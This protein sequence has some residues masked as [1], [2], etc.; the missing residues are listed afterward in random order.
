LVGPASPEFGA[1]DTPLGAKSGKMSGEGEV[2][3]VGED[4]VGA[5]MLKVIDKDAKTDAKAPQE[6]NNKGKIDPHHGADTTYKKLFIGGLAWQT[7]TERLKEHFAHYG[8]LVEAVVITDKT[9]GRSKGYGF[10]TY[11]REEDA[12]KA[13]KNTS[14]TIDGRRTNCNLAAFGNV[15]RDRPGA[16]NNFEGRNNYG[17]RGGHN[18][19][20]YYYD[21]QQ[22]MMYGNM[23]QQMDNSQYGGMG[24]PGAMGGSPNQ[25]GNFN[26][27][28]YMAFPAMMMQP[29]AAGMMMTPQGFMMA[30]QQQFDGA[31]GGGMM[32]GG[33]MQHG[34]SPNQPDMGDLQALGGAM[35]ELTLAN[36]SDDLE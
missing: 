19:G 18:G 12:S 36:E 24:F 10:V 21:Q 32:Y 15:R 22:M 25:M 2:V 16:R 6:K 23:Q 7:S 34:G 8:D 29:A 31:N 33:G 20:P 27:M 17:G 5:D 26:Q 35:T 4:G 1:A 14:P 9:T 28:P 30:P 13:L 3:Q 11:A